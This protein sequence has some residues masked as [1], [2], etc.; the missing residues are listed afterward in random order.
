MPDAFSG[1]FK[2]ALDGIAQFA[3]LGLPYDAGSSYRPGARLRPSER[4]RPRSTPALKT[5]WI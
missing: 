4:F 5:A 3:L 2:L 1:V